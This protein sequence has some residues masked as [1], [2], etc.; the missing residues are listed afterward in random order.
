M[1]M[2]TVELSRASPPVTRQVQE[3]QVVEIE[4]GKIVEEAQ[5]ELQ[6]PLPSTPVVPST[7]VGSD[8]MDTSCV[9]AAFRERCRRKKAALLP[10][11][12]ARK[13]RAKRPPPSVV[14]RSARVAGRFSSGASITQQ[15]KTLMI[16]LELAREGEVISEESLQA[17]LRYFEE[18]PMTAEHLTACLALFGW[19]PNVLP[20]VEEGDVDVV[21]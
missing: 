4:D 12:V 1:S 18:K 19:L 2:F 16:Q 11:P 10:R 14:R 21:V 20:V 7:P 3:S 8:F 15:Q 9:L 6:P 13:P 17:Y 5:P